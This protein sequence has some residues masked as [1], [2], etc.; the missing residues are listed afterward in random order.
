MSIVDFT[1]DG[2]AMFNIQAS[3]GA[4]ASSFSV[5]N[6]KGP[7]VKLSLT[8]MAIALGHQ[9]HHLNAEGAFFFDKF[10][11]IFS[12]ICALFI[13]AS[14]FHFFLLLP[15]FQMLLFVASLIRILALIILSVL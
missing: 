13:G 3:Y 12:L 2:A 6:L 7:S 14:I 4:A 10:E 11:R 15:W 5:A 9:V 1:L 8:E